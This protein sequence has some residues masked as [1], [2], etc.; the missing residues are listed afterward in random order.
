VAL[1]AAHPEPA[2][3]RVALGS[4]GVA[5]MLKVTYA[6]TPRLAAMLRTPRGTVTL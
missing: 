4:L 6:V 1:A 3:I 5:E 2:A